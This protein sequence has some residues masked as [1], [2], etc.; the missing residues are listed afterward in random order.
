[1]P[2]LY[3][4]LRFEQ[5]KE[6]PMSFLNQCAFVGMKV[7]M[8][9]DEEARNLGRKGP[10][11][12]STGELVKRVRYTEYREN[13]GIDRYFSEPGIYERDGS[14]FVLMDDRTL[15]EVVDGLQTPLVMAGYDFEVHADSLDEYNRRCEELWHEPVNRLKTISSFDQESILDNRVRIG[16]LPETQAWILDTIIP[17]DG[18]RDEDKDLR[19]VVT[20][21]NYHSEVLC[22]DVTAYN[23]EGR[24]CFSTFFRDEHIKEIVRGNLWKLENGEPL[25]F[26]S[27]QDEATFAKGLGKAREVRNPKS[28]R[29]SW[30]LD[31]FLA[32]IKADLVDCMTNGVLP[33]ATKPRISAYRYEDRDLGERLRQETIKGFDLNDLPTAA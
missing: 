4:G 5:T 13:Y 22:Y 12:G 11:D 8:K 28:G 32:A 14:W 30:T 16:D 26:Q 21:I 23:E 3:F 19:F 10:P 18:L 9:M 31:E 29:Y 33:F 20:R 6:I 1:M 15:G 7:V 2:R 25:T 17:V 24:S 27:I